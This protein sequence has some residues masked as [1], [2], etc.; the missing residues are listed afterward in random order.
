MVDTHVGAQ[1]RLQALETRVLLL[2][3]PQKSQEGSR[4]GEGQLCPL[5]VAH[6]GPRSGPWA[7]GFC[8]ARG[9]LPGNSKLC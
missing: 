6:M 8:L 5:N 4:M 9:P 3:W 2:P 7:P 1:K